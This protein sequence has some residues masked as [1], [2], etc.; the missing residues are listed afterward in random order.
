M[1]SIATPQIDY[2]HKLNLHTVCGAKAALERVFAETPPKCVLD[3]GCGTGT[4]LRAALDLGVKEI[5]GIDGVPI[6]PADLLISN[7]FFRVEDLSRTIDLGRKFDM[8]LCL[9]VAEHLAADT[10]PRLIATLVAHSDVILFSAASPGQFGQHHV[11]CRWPSYWQTLFNK[12]G[13]ACDD[14]V[15]WQTWEIRDI[16]PWYRQNMFQARRAPEVAGREP[17]LRPVIHPEMLEIKA[18]DAFAEV[19]RSCIDRIEAGSKSVYWYGSLF[20]RALVAK[21]RRR[22]GRRRPLT[23]S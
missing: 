3:V 18:F 13:Y 8:V 11:N 22:L 6:L 15:R 14:R 17:R 21:V 16:E 4:W 1:K 20:P 10:A 12:Q 7:Q 5:C 9:E 19:E 2:E 23:V